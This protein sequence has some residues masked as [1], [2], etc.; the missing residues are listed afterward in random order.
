MGQRRAQIILNNGEARHPLKKAL[1]IGRQGEIRDRTVE[2]QHY[3]IAGLNL[4]D[5][6]INYWNTVHFDHAV[7]EHGSSSCL[8]DRPDQSEQP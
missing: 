1:L 4:P 5:A 2:G 8:E 6:T 3:R 7:A